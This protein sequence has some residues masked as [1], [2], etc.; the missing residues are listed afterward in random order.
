MRRLFSVLTIFATLILLGH[1]DPSFA[2]EIVIASS[3]DDCSG[4]ADCEAGCDLYPFYEDEDVAEEWD[5]DDT[6][7]GQREDTWFH[8]LER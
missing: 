3:D 2:Q 8:N 1:Q 6:W 7:P 5:D 4:S